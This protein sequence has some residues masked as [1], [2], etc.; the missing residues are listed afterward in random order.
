M[1]RL[2]SARLGLMTIAV[3]ATTLL[4]WLA[5]AGSQRAAR[6]AA[7]ADAPATD[8]ARASAEEP[9]RGKLLYDDKREVSPEQRAEFITRAH[10][11]RQPPVPVNRASLVGTTL[12]QV[13]CRMKITDLGGTTPK[14]DCVL[15]D[16]EEIRIKYGSGAEV[17]AE[18]AA[19]RLL[20]ALGFGADDIT[21]VRR[22]RCYGCPEEPFVFMKA[23]EVTR[24]EPLYEKT[25]DFSKFEDFEWVGLERKFNARPIEAGD[26]EGWSFFE[27]NTVDSE[28]GG[29]P[30]AH[31]DALRM[32]AVLLAHWDNKSENQRLVCLA[33]D[34]REGEPCARPFLLLQDVGATFGPM[35]LDLAE[36]ET[37][38][39][40]DDRPTCAVSM[41]T[42]PFEGATFGA[43]NISEGG[44]RFI[45]DLLSQLSDQQ[46]TDLFTHA[47][48]AEKRAPFASVRRVSEWVRVFRQKVRAI[49]EG[50]PCP[51]A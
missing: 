23:V 38:P 28:R 14:F 37:T 36:W 13:T 25:I 32:M 16:G 2:D 22:L 10:V 8:A 34:W 41:R 24:T 19:T 3:A 9:A 46:L 29:S 4:V 1:W 6:N 27:L 48:V 11:W 47:R 35:K 43:A 44:R 45:A 30:R 18:A 31:V 12:D 20:K 33:H 40:W 5:F 7:T 26:L 39:I 15:E 51:V 21:L 17:P 42:L 49:S 50:P